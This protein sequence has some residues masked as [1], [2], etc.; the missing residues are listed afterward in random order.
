MTAMARR[1]SIQ[2]CRV[3]SIPTF[4][5][6]MRIPLLMGR[7]FTPIRY[8]DLAAGRHHQP[9][10]GRALLVWTWTQSDAA[11]DS[12]RCIH[13]RRSSAWS[14]IFAASRETTPF[15]RSTTSHSRRQAIS[16]GDGETHRPA[17]AGFRGKPSPLMLVVR[18][19]V[20]AR[21][22]SSAA[23]DCNPQ[24]SIQHCRS[25]GVDTARGAGRCDCRSPV[26]V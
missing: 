13:G 9:G 11:C 12:D 1:A 4:F 23:T 17:A 18:S 25:C 21:A 6:A 2:R 10:D 22:I 19:R 15:G 7:E 5:R 24:Q 20:S 3:R 16:G 14:T 8:C 26:P